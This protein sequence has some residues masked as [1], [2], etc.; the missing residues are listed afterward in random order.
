[1]KITDF[2]QQVKTKNSTTELNKDIYTGHLRVNLKNE[3]GIYQ[4]LLKSVTL[5]FD[6][7]ASY[8]CFITTFSIWPNVAVVS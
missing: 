3:T 2:L 4:Q 6:D 8:I 7:S 1:M 5:T